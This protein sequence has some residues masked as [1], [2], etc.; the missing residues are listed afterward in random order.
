MAPFL[1]SFDPQETTLHAVPSTHQKLVI[2]SEA[3]D[4]RRNPHHEL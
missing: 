4:L 1:F 2:L 3:K